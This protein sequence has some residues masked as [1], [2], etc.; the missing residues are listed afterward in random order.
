[1]ENPKLG[2]FY[3]MQNWCSKDKHW[4]TSEVYLLLEWK[5]IVSTITYEFQYIA[6]FG[7]RK[8]TI[9]YTC[10]SIEDFNKDWTPLSIESSMS[11]STSQIVNVPVY[12]PNQEAFVTTIT[13]NLTTTVN[14][15]KCFKKK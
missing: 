5:R 1:M 2:V 13:T 11:R 9:A 14:N 4:G 7:Y 10:E 12:I 6:K 3:K 15:S 8:K